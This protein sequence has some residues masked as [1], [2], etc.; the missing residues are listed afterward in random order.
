ML[1]DQRKSLRRPTSTT[2]GELPT[3]EERVNLGVYGVKRK[4]SW[5]CWR[6]G[7]VEKVGAWWC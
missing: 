2:E 5:V 1:E 7:V 6:G 4:R 3:M